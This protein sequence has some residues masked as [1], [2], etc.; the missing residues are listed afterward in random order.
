MPGEY[1]FNTDAAEVM[2]ILEGELDVLLPGSE[3][4]LRV[5]GGESF[6]VLKNDCVRYPF[7][8]SNVLQCSINFIICL[9][10]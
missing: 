6:D 3:D 9:W 4:W 8:F 1:D 7:A 2:E 5:K 10:F